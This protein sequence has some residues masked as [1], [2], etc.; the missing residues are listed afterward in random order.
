VCVSLSVKL[1]L[2]HIAAVRTWHMYGCPLRIHHS[3]KTGQANAYTFTVPLTDTEEDEIPLRAVPSRRRLR[4]VD[5]DAE[6][7][8]EA[9]ST[10]GDVNA[11]A[12]PAAAAAATSPSDGD[13]TTGADDSLTL[14]AHTSTVLLVG[15]HGVR[16]YS[17]LVSFYITALCLSMLVFL[18]CNAYVWSHA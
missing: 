5:P 2:E 6:P 10:A 9:D 4:R 17:L 16:P 7:E 8:P 15:D 18:R 3:L 11:N 1:E 12:N 14:D 13:D